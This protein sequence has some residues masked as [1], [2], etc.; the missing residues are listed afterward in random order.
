[1]SVPLIAVAVGTIMLNKTLMRKYIVKVMN[2]CMHTSVWDGTDAG[3]A[4]VC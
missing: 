1:M 2:E 3:K 4:R